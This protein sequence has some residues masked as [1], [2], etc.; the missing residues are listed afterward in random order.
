LYRAEAELAHVL[1]H[2][3]HRG[4]ALM[5]MARSAA[6]GLERVLGPDH[7]DTQD[8]RNH[9]AMAYLDAGRLAE[10]IALLEPM[11]KLSESKFGPDHP[12]TLVIRGNLATAYRQAGRTA[13]AIGLHEATL[14]LQES[15]LGPD[16][17][18]TLMSRSNLARAYLAAGRTA[19]AIKLYEAT[20]KL[21]ESK[22]GPDHS[23]TLV[24]VH[25]LAHAF[26]A[27]RPAEAEPLFRR[28]LEGYRRQQGPN[29]PSTIDLTSDLASVMGRTGRTADHQAA[30]GKPQAK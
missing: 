23:D 27:S 17:S 25:S 28:A 15:K 10:A 24:S 6:E 20:L 16:H 29:G 2:R 7:P 19:E 18:G 13:E 11:L 14:K 12:E 26:E 22:L 30:R 9:L 1:G 4:E 21:Q 5:G 3:G 8:S